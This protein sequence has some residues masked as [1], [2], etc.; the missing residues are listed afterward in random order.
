MMG[1]SAGIAVTRLSFAYAGQ[2]VL[3]DINL[4]IR[5]GTFSA[6]LGPNGA[7]KSTFLS[8]LSGLL[9]ARQGTI[10]INGCDSRTQLQQALAQTGIVFQQ[11]A[12][13]LD[14]TVKQNM[15]YG[16]GLRGYWGGTARH[17]I[18]H[19]LELMDLT[20][21]TRARVRELNGGHRRRLEVARA[22][23]HQPK[24]LILDEPTVGL[25]IPTRDELVKHVHK[26]TTDS[27][28]TVLWATHLVDEIYSSDDLILMHGGQ[29]RLNGPVKTLLEQYGHPTVLS[30]FQSLTAADLSQDD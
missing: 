26:L 24:V 10:S 23:V 3:T 16:A 18:Q 30:L 5:R 6:L 29:V 27:G 7:G 12:L 19:A 13:D 28:I 15:I 11:S 25:D 20:D 14:L 21:Q 17:N 22:L 8:L 4:E 9:I 1:D 2:P